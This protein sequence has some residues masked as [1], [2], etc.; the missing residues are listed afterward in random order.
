MPLFALLAAA[1]SVHYVWL[2]ATSGVAAM[3]RTA[4]APSK[5]QRYRARRKAE[6]MKL[7]RIWI[8]DPRS[9]EIAERARREAES[10]R[11]AEDEQEALDFIE[12]AIRD[13]DLPE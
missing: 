7:V 2:R 9:P 6:G 11:G 13:L 3:A 10:L 12:A 4:Q 5:F 1:R 8:P